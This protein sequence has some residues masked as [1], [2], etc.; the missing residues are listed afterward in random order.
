M[1]VVTVTATVE[2]SNVPP[3]VRLDVADTGSPVFTTVTITRLNPDGTT[4]PV[5][6]PDGNPLVM[7]AGAGLVYDNE[8]PL[9]E[10]VTYS[11]LETP[12]NVTTPVTVPASQVWLEHPGIPTLSVPVRL[13][14]GTFTRRTRAAR[15]G[16]FWPMGRETPVVFGD[17]SR[18][19][20][21]TQL[22]LV[23]LT[24]TEADALDALLQ[25]GSP[26]LLNVPASLGYNFSTAYISLGDLEVAVATEMVTEDVL[27][28]TMP[29]TVVD[30]PAGGSQSQR[31]YT[32]LL[33][34]PTYAALQDAYVDY[35]ALLA[36]P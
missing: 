2:A 36:G 8:V 16:V 29:I 25:D 31:T 15:Q 26:L 3:R 33:V 5:R 18:K 9:G 7:S 13:G 19:S 28:Y 17:G 10:A 12:A 22:V 14:R 30:R 23:A 1:S 11:S 34:F 20:I 4:V 27:T 35:A 21:Q 24:S 6:T 32:D